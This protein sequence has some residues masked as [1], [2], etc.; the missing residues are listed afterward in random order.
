MTNST[1][2]EPSEIDNRKQLIETWRKTTNATIEEL[3]I[4]R[5]WLNT[6]LDFSGPIET[7][8]VMQIVDDLTRAGLGMWLFDNDAD[9]FALTDALIGEGCDNDR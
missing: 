1:I 5:A 6:W 4:F 2:A 9:I 3:Y 8:L 7:E